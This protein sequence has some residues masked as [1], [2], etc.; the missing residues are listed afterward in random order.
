MTIIRPTTDRIQWNPN[1]ADVEIQD[2]GKQNLGFVFKE[3]FGSK[4][5]NWLFKRVSSWL[6]F[7]IDRIDAHETTED[8]TFT[9]LEEA[10]L[11]LAMIKHNDYTISIDATDF[12]DDT[13]DLEIDG[14]SGKGTILIESSN[15][16]TVG[17]VKFQ[18]V[19]NFIHTTISSGDGLMTTKLNGVI[20]DNCPNVTFVRLKAEQNEASSVNDRFIKVLNHSSLRITTNLQVDAQDLDVGDHMIFID[21]TSFFYLNSATI[22]PPNTVASVVRRSVI[23]CQGTFR[24]NNHPTFGED[25]YRHFG[26]QL[27]GTVIPRSSEPWKLFYGNS[28][29]PANFVLN[30]IR[31]LDGNLDIEGNIGENERGVRCENLSGEGVIR[32]KFII[33]ASDDV[34]RRIRFINV[35]PEIIFEE[36]VLSVKSHATNTPIIL[37]NCAKI[38]MANAYLRTAI[39]EGGNCM[40]ID[41]CRGFINALIVSSGSNDSNGFR[42]CKITGN[43]HININNLNTVALNSSGAQFEFIKVEESTVKLTGTT[44]F[45]GTDTIRIGFDGLAPSHLI[46]ISDGEIEYGSSYSGTTDLA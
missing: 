26:A 23:N 35:Q 6:N 25:W 16:I 12:D 19:D 33:S 1:E 32:V 3:K 7:C 31:R 15:A 24:V 41:N 14:I 39:G 4:V 9:D 17:S 38:R 27:Q 11:F 37:K 29:I 22:T 36:D 2:S 30:R 45:G 20:I 43:S 28:S 44:T 18:N 42:Y 21:E 34:A 8:M 5:A 40:I 13:F 46:A 10:V